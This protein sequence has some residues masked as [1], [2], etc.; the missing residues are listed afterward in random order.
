VRPLGTGPYP[1]TLLGTAPR[2]HVLTFSKAVPLVK[3]GRGGRAA[4]FSV[5]DDM[6]GWL[7]VI[8]ASHPCC[9][10]GTSCQAREQMQPQV[11]R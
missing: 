4:G 8:A 7:A 6:W 10:K 11:L 9:G 5:L 2:V 3:G 1:Q